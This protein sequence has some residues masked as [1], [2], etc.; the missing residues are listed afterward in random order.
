MIAILYLAAGL[1]S[2]MRGGDKLLEVLNG[3]PL[4]RLQ[5]MRGASVARTF[6]T[7][8]PAP[9]P[10]HDVVPDTIT[11]VPVEGQM[12]D[13]IRAGLAALP[14][15][16]RGVIILPAD[17]PDITAEDLKILHAAAQ[18]NAAPIVRATTDDGI[19]GHPVYFAR[20]IWK[21]FEILTGD[22]GAVRICTTYEAETAFIPLAGQK[23]RLDLDT[24]E[25]WKTY[26]KNS[27]R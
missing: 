15:Q 24:P 2:R 18:E 12:S 10:R 7:L 4:L 9:H 11:K 20:R 14:S 1:S 13:S 17:M 23:A 25:D 6:V 16:A 3:T 19:P 27:K 26:R 22:R 21:D 5:L 8:P